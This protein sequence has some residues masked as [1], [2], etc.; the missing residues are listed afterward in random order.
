MKKTNA[1]KIVFLGLIS[2]LSLCS[3]RG[4][5]PENT[6]GYYHPKPWGHIDYVFTYIGYKTDGQM[7][8]IDCD[9]PY[10]LAL[11]NTIESE[12]DYYA[13]TE[14]AISVLVYLTIDPYLADDITNAKYLS[15]IYYDENEKYKH[16]EDEGGWLLYE[17]EPEDFFSDRFSYTIEKN[18]MNYN[19]EDETYISTEIINA[20]V[21]RRKSGMLI[22]PMFTVVC[23]MY[24]E[25]RSGD[26]QYFTEYEWLRVPFT[27]ENNMFRL[28]TEY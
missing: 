23:L 18:I 6:T 9:Y 28:D 20:L 22:R 19:F 3:C 24:D 11:A 16:L 8:D 25:N 7:Y 10:T 15:S 17:F 14:H 13:E 26:I 4:K 5:G 27:I 1:K 21:N 12:K 2:V